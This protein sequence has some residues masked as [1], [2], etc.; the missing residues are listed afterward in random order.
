MNEQTS[1]FFMANIVKDFAH[2]YPYIFWPIFA[3]ASLTVFCYILLQ[4]EYWWI[5]GFLNLSSIHYLQEQKVYRFRDKWNQPFD[6][7]CGTLQ[8]VTDLPGASQQLD[9]R[10][11]VVGSDWPIWGRMVICLI[12]YIAQQEYQKRKGK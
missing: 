6:V 7:T 9:Y 10:G 2:A 3:F 12:Y 4:F 11:L 8:L 1:V 5:K